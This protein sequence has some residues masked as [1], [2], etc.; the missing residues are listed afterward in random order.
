MKNRLIAIKVLVRQILSDLDAGNTNLTEEELEES[1]EFLKRITDKDKYYSREE[2]AE[3]LHMSVQNF[4]ALRRKGEIPQGI[5]R[6]SITNL[7][8]SKKVLDEYIETH[9][10]RHHNKYTDRTKY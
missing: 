6:K 4:D 5:K 8:W 9:K 7:Q 3:Y 2:A 10:D 1:I